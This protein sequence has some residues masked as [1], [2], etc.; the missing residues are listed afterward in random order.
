MED[1][2]ISPIEPGTSNRADDACFVEA[3][4]ATAPLRDLD[5]VQDRQVGDRSLG[6][7]AILIELRAG[8]CAIDNRFDSLTTRLDSMNCATA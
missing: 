6:M 4:K 3:D 7:E 8:F 5:E 1:P 2:I